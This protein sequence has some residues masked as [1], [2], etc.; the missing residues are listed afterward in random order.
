MRGRKN[1]NQTYHDIQ[2]ILKVKIDIMR[3]LTITMMKASIEDQYMIENA[4]NMVDL[5]FDIC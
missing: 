5:N 1:Q 3:L 4:L 2:I